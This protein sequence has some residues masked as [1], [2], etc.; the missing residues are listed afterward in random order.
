MNAYVAVTDQDWFDYLA[1]LPS[2]DEVNFWQ[3]TPW[4]GSLRVL[5]RG[6]PLLFKLK[7]PV[8]AIGG[9]GFFEHYTELP[10][11]LAWEAFG[12]KNGAGSLY[13]LRLRTARLR[14]VPPHPWDDY[15]IGCLILVEPF[16]WPDS[17]WIRQPRDWK[18]N[19]VRG[20]RYD[21]TRGTGYALWQEVLNR[22]QASPPVGE[23]G[24][25][26]RGGYADA[27]PVRRR[28]GQG[29]FRILVTDAYGRE[30]AI[31]RERALPAL[32]AAH[33]KPFPLV[34]TH[35]VRN[36]LLLRSDLH[37]LFDVGY[38]TVTPEY[39]VE[40]SRR[41]RDDFDDGGTYLDYHGRSIVLPRASDARP[42]PDYLSW[43][44]EN[45][46]RG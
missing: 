32:E 44:N 8:N 22:L 36:G 10:L 33:I 9:G 25:V 17:D 5:K 4:G 21:L 28:I 46:F 30:C 35:D 24:L 23:G 31:S 3:P 42:A 27:G 15:S 11:S 34:E 41:I 38:V 45:K 6:E 16:F 29:T 14:S 13:E 12:D 1:A 37:R 7:S 19:I 39:R 26:V 18:P 2:V 20:K 40:V 43:H